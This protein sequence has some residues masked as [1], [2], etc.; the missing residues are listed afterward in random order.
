NGNEPWVNL[1]RFF[2]EP[3]RIPYRDTPGDEE[4][5]YVVFVTMV[6]VKLE[7]A[8]QESSMLL[9]PELSFRERSDAVR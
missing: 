2:A 6:R 8:L 3:D 9:N 4:D 5:D 1:N 7:I